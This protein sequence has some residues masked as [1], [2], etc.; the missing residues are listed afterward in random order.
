[1]MKLSLWY[2]G[3]SRPLALRF[4]SLE[5]HAFFL[6]IETTIANMIVVI[7]HNFIILTKQMQLFTADSASQLIPSFRLIRSENKD[8]S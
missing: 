6:G 1:M 3:P 7:R 8:S 2:N 5:H 4:A